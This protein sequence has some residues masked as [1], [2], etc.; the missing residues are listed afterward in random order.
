MALDISRLSLVPMRNGEMAGTCPFCG[1]TKRHFYVNPHKGVYVCFRCGTAGRLDG[2]STVFDDGAV[3]AAE[4][5][6]EPLADD[7]RIGQVYAVLL[8]TLDLSPEHLAHLRSPARGLSDEVIGKKG[9][10][11][12]PS[13]RRT[14]IGKRVAEKV[15][16]RGVPGFYLYRGRAGRRVWCV[17]GPPGLLIP[18][19]N[20]EGAIWGVQI[21][22]DDRSSWPKY[23]WLS[24]AAARRGT[25]GVGAKARF[26]VARAGRNDGTVWITEGPLKADI[27]AS[28]LGRTFVAVPGVQCWR[29][30]GLIGALKR[31]RVRVVVLAY[32]MDA[33]LN[34]HVESA[35]LELGSALEQA[36]IH[37]VY[38]W[39]RIEEGKGIDDVL[40]N[41][42]E[43]RVM[44]KG[45]WKRRV[46]S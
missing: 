23:V 27:A 17:A 38:A 13:G 45:S 14:E 36:G 1:D 19:R 6:A 43:V 9:Y 33:V 18:V 29:S 11:T 20:F 5:P 34:P 30:S 40:L 25:C 42:G 41:G 21:R 2:S 3:S 22:P 15:E 37:A 26:H 31:E 12:L 7:E 8:E 46:L 10:R 28:K 24:S 16:P 44:S 32:D 35:A 39:W 4:E